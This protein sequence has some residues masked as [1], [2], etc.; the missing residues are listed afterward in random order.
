LE[1]DDRLPLIETHRIALAVEQRLRMHYPGADIMIH[2]DPVSLGD[3]R[4]SA[5]PQQGR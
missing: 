5:R 4:G 1:L 3:E 2:Q